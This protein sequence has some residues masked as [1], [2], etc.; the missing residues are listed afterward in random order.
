[1]TAVRANNATQEESEDEGGDDE[2]G[3]DDDDDGGEEVCPPGCDQGLYE[4]VSS[5]AG[6]TLRLLALMPDPLAV[7]CPV[8]HPAA[9]CSPPQLPTAA[10]QTITKPTDQLN[11][12]TNE[13]LP[14]N[15]R[16]VTCVRSG[17]TR[18][19]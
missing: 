14:H 6:R 8:S 4:K 19:S 11:T 10:A 2:E 1:M 16:C 13:Q 9:F 5:A 15:R 3:D 18:R 7:H 17:W 12:S